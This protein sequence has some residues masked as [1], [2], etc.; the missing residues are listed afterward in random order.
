M[1]GRW[2][3]GID[4]STRLDGNA[5]ADVFPYIEAPDGRKL[6]LATDADVELAKKIVANANDA[7]PLPRWITEK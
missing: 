3:I 2:S 6:W 1:I 4:R 7:L 5:N